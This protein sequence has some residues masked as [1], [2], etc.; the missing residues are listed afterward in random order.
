MAK[1]AIVEALER[2]RL[3]LADIRWFVPSNVSL[4]SWRIL[5]EVLGVGADKICTEMIASA[6][7]TV[8]CDHIINLVEME[9]AGALR[10]GDHLLLF[11][12]GF[13]AS[14]SVLIIRH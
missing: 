12:F 6:G 9:R 2:A 5:A 11:T 7:H 10:R 14:W 3:T 4:R 1:L 13:G 8:S